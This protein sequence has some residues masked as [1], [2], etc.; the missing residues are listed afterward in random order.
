M[1][2]PRPLSV[3][4]PTEL[5][6][7]LAIAASRNRRSMM[8]EVLERLQHSFAPPYGRVHKALGEPANDQ[9]SAP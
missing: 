7:R 4:L 8:A 3:E 9:E 6:Q 1:R 5:R 2:T